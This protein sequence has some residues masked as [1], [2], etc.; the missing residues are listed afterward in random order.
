V[1][2]PKKQLRREMQKK[3]LLSFKE[4]EP[5]K[6]DKPL[7]S[8]RKARY[9]TVLSICKQKSGRKRWFQAANDHKGKIFF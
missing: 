6:N 7:C 5:D 4:A 8:R 3:A 2:L 1:P 9:K